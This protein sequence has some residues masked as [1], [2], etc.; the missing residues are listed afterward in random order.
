MTR[1]LGLFCFGLALLAFSCVEKPPQ[2]Y[3]NVLEISINGSPILTQFGYS[4]NESCGTIFVSSWINEEYVLDMQISDIGAIRKISLIGVWPKNDRDESFRSAD[5]IPNST[6]RI[7]NFQFDKD[8]RSIS[9]EFEGQLTDPRPKKDKSTTIKGRVE[10]KNLII[11]PCRGLLQNVKATINGNPYRENM[12]YSIS[13]SSGNSAGLS[14]SENGYSITLFTSQQPQSLDLKTYNF[15]KNSTINF[16]TL[17]KYIGPVRST[18]NITPLKT[19]SE[20]EKYQCEGS[21]AITEKTSSNGRIFTKGV[22]SLK[23]YDKNSN[24]LLYSLENGEFIF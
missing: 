14:F 4:I 22:F 20:W 19:D 21:F 5:F 6:F 18:Q 7:N 1:F 17:E 3:V 24:T 8:S 16:I 23:A 13:E 9:F 10:D 12:T 15:S 2:K 11:S